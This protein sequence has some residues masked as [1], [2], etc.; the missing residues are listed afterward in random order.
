MLFRAA[1]RVG[2][3]GSEG[4]RTDKAKKQNKG[5]IKRRVAKTVTTN[6]FLLDFTSYTHRSRSVRSS[7]FR[8]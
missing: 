1:T 5:E 7:S 3:W 2:V 6:V 8:G 4:E